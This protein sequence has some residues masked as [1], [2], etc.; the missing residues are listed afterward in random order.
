[1]HLRLLYLGV[2]AMIFSSCSWFEDETPESNWVAS[3][4]DLGVIETSTDI[5]ARDGGYS[6]YYQGQVVWAF[7]DTFLSDFNEQGTNFISNSWSV[8]DDLDATDGLT[9]FYEFEDGAGLP[10]SFIPHT[11]R[12]EVFNE[13]HFANNC[14]DSCGSRYA[15][16]PQTLLNDPNN[17]RL[18]FFYEKLY[19][20]PGAFN[21]YALGNGIGLIHHL[22]E[23]AERLGFEINAL[24]PTLF[25]LKD[26]PSFGDAALIVNDE[27][28]AYGCTLS[29]LQK[30]CKLARIPLTGLNNPSSWKYYTGGGWSGDLS[31]AS[32]VFNG[33]DIMT[34]AFNEYLGKYLAVFSEPL[35]TNV[36]MRTSDQL[37]GGWSAASV[38]FKAE[39]SLAGGG[40]VYDALWHPELDE[41]LGQSIYVTYSRGTAD[42]QS[43]FR[44]VRVDFN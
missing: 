28:F 35:S 11:N 13:R 3:V 33:N 36:V 38:L 43:E 12:E 5:K 26:E 20:E 14:S 16:W 2:F 7:G 42:F 31:E 41:N 18:I 32:N 10:G 24:F 37:W 39:Q 34:I 22:S 1:M 23:P 21:F 9:G 4:E 40:T 30:P 17:N 19:A 27:I 6:A 29:G 8:S 44:L 25:N 15:L